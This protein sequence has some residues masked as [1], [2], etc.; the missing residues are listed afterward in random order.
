ML[1]RF[2]RWFA[3]GL[4]AGGLALTATGA[5][6]PQVQTPAAPPAS[7][8][9][10]GT[11]EHPQ[12]VCVDLQS[13]PE[14]LDVQGLVA[15]KMALTSEE[16][17]RASREDQE[18]LAEVQ[19]TLGEGPIEI[20]STANGP[21][22]L[23]IRMEEVSADKAKELKLPADRGV[24]VTHV[25]PDSPAAKAGLKAGDVITEFDGQRVEGTV[26]LQRLVH[27]VPVGRTV[28][29]SIWR[30]GSAQSL[31]VEISA[32][33]AGASGD[34][35]YMYV[36]PNAPGTSVQIPPIPPIPAIRALPSI[37][38]IDIGPMG[39][40][41]MFGSPVLGV[42]AEDLSGQLGNY[43]GAPDGQGILVREVMPG[44]PA[45]KAGLKAGD[46]I[47][48]VDGRRVKDAAEL[49]AA[50]REKTFK[51]AEGPDSGKA[52]TVTSDLTVLRAGKELTLR[53]ELQVP[54]SRNRTAHR[55]AV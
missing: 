11:P 6:A 31:S 2:T 1:S 16:M 4:L 38:A 8:P 53:V 35:N 5:A 54:A 49:R 32:R 17:T 9:C 14:I 13:L 29:L 15:Q 51:A 39:A 19:D 50:L 36:G 48:R 20:F 42:D 7:Q 33:R 23:G 43:F 10:V 55:V 41:R 46:V 44:T 45:E 26:A 28:S 12:C 3:G 24:L 21:S 25:A 27:E 40:F 18:A 52:P 34:Q 47:L 30:D 22:W 37:P